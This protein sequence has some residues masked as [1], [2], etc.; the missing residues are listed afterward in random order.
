[1]PAFLPLAAQRV[2]YRYLVTLLF[3]K[4]LCP[5]IVWRPTELLYEI[6]YFSF[7]C[8]WSFLV[9]CTFL[10]SPL[11]PLGE[12]PCALAEN[13]FTPE[14]AAPKLSYEGDYINLRHKPAFLAFTVS[15]PWS[16]ATVADCNSKIALGSQPSFSFVRNCS[17]STQY[18]S[19]SFCLLLLS[20]NNSLFLLLSACTGLPDF[21]SFNKTLFYCKSVLIIWREKKTCQLL[22]HILDAE[23]EDEGCRKTSVWGEH[24]W[25]G[26]SRV[27]GN[28]FYQTQ[29]NFDLIYFFCVAERK[30]GNLLCCETNK[31]KRNGGT[32]CLS[33]GPIVDMDQYSHFSPPCDGCCGRQPVAVDQYSSSLCLAWGG[34]RII[35]FWSF[36]SI[37]APEWMVT[38]SAWLAEAFKVLLE[39]TATCLWR[40]PL[41]CF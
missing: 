3:S 16:V 22:K 24:M 13:V 19:S 40:L 35:S 39:D 10:V 5:C 17:I 6:N 34:Q 9:M 11:P 38:S 14:V 36:R 25:R 31:E 4:G 41:D 26:E 30:P 23:A 8:K 27:T 2:L 7:S 15:P 29:K 18:S 37:T 33:G 1:M 32:L 21:C 20:Y 12:Y 28:G